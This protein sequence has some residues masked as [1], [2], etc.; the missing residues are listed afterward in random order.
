MQFLALQVSAVGSHYVPRYTCDLPRLRRTVL[1][2][3]VAL[4]QPYPRVLLPLQNAPAL[5]TYKRPKVLNSTE[6]TFNDGLTVRI[7]PFILLLLYSST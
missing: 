7:N 3:T 6:Q 4:K 2:Y 5:S 1:A